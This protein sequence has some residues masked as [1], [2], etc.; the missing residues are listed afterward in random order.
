MMCN[1][2]AYLMKEL[3]NKR[4]ESKSQNTKT[5]VCTD[6]RNNKHILQFRSLTVEVNIHSTH[7]D[8]FPL[9]CSW[10]SSP[11]GLTVNILQSGTPTSL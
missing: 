5:P 1:A 3:T 11:F 10:I 2:A 4:N 9:V 8:L 7:E 6:Y